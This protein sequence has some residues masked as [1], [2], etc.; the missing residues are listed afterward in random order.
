MMNNFMIL[1][2]SLRTRSLRE[3]QT[4]KAHHPSPGR[5]WS[6]RSTTDLSPMSLGI[7]SSLCA[8]KSAL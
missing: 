7:S 1:G 5:G 3:M 6:C 2:L 8:E 4:E